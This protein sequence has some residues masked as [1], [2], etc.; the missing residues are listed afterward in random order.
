MMSSYTFRPLQGRQQ[1][2]CTQ[3]SNNTTDSADDMPV[4]SYNRIN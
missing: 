3:G 4:Y 1:G 2:V